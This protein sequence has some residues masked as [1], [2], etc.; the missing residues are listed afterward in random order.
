MNIIDEPFAH[1]V[2]DDFFPVETALAMEAEFPPYHDPAWYCYHNAIENKKTL[3]LWHMFP[4]TTYREMQRLCGLIVEG[5]V[6]DY[7]LHGGGWHMHANGGNL[8]PHQDYEIHPKLSTQRQWN[9]IVYLSS[10]YR[11][12]YG[13][14]LGLWKDGELVKKIWPRFNRA[15]I[16][17]TRGSVHGLASEVQCP[18]DIYRKSIAVYYLGT[19]EGTRTK[20][21]FY[22]RPHQQD[23]AS[24]AAMIERRSKG[25]YK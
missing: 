14:E 10:D 13:G 23:D 7:G 12:E 22:P 1:T 19:G 3:N 24:V 6:A 25:E 4:A 8:N 5:A 16:F 20:A 21:L 15:V 11:E 2:I 9:L 17:D 18:D